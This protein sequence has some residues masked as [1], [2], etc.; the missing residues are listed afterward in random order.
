MARAPKPIRE[1]DRKLDEALDQTFPASD[2]VAIGRNDHPGK[3][4]DAS[5]DDAWCR[6]QTGQARSGG[7]A[8]R[9]IDRGAQFAW[10]G[11]LA[12]GMASMDITQ[13]RR[14]GFGPG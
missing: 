4:D 7:S 9:A 5:K 13:E 3:P 11:E 12:S 6:I 10:A 2:P 1:I 8:L 14:K